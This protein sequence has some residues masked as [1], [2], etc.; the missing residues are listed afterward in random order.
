MPGLWLCG[1]FTAKPFAAMLDALCK[2]ENANK[3]MV[4]WQTKSRI[5]PRGVKDEWRRMKQMPASVL[6][7]AREGRAESKERP[8]AVNP[9][10]ASSPASYRALMTE[11]DRK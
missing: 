2:P 3:N 9:S 6:A 5:Q 8:G 4:F 1:H 11:I 7:W 10:D